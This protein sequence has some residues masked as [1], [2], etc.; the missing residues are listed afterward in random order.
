M[1]EGGGQEMMA[2]MKAA[3]LG[4]LV[5]ALCGAGAPPV[6]ATG[7][8]ALLDGHEGSNY[9]DM[10]NMTDMGNMTDMV[11]MGNMT[12]G[13]RKLLGIRDLLDG[14]LNATMDDMMNMSMM[15]NMTE[16]HSDHVR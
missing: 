9:T 5:A 11:D 1:G 13:G 2:A 8:R 3:A 10:A 16:D 15:A 7:M 14:H 12:E 6:A 4:A